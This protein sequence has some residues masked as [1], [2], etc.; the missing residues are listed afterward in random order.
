MDAT[1]EV[2]KRFDTNRKEIGIRIPD[3]NIIRMIAEQLGNPIATTSLHDDEDKILEYFIDPYEI[4]ER[5]DSKVDLIIDGGL[6]N[7]DASTVVNCTDGI[8]I[9]RQGAGEIEI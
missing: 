6:G 7:L 4:Y 1:T 3:N 8:E 2:S 5:Y 9:I